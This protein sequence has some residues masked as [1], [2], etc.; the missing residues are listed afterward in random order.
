MKFYI[1]SDNVDSLVAMRLVGIEG[2]VIH[3][4][5][6]FLERLNQLIEDP[7]FG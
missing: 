2:E 7:S 4:R 3:E 1:L 6:T 5:H